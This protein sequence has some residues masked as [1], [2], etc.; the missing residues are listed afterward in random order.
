MPVANYIPNVSAASTTSSYIHETFNQ[1][2]ANGCIGDPLGELAY[3]YIRVSSAQQAEDGRSGLP[4][5][6]Q[7]CDEAARQQHLRIQ[8]EFVFVDDGFSGFEFENRPA[9]NRLREE[10]K[11]SPRTRYIVIEHLDRLSRNARWHQGFLLEEFSKYHVTPIFWKAFGSEIERAVLGTIAE[12]GMRSEI[13][14]MNEGLRHKAVSGRVTAKRPRFGYLFVDSEGQPSEKARK[15]THY[16]LHPENAKIVR[17]IFECIIKERKSL[18]MIA[19]EMNKE[20]IPTTF[21]GKIWCSATIWHIVSD[22]TYKGDFY[23]HRYYMVKTGRFNAQ[24]RATQMTKQRPPAEWIKVNVPPIVTPSEWQ[25]VQDIL[26][27][28]QSRSTR[29]MKKRE[30]L[31]SSFCK[32]DLCKYAYVSIMGGSKKSP[33][34][35]Y[36]CH[37]RNTDRALVTDVACHSPYVT[38][39][40]LEKFVWGK[41]EELVTNPELF[42]RLAQEAENDTQVVEEEIQLQYIG[43]QIADITGRY[44]QWKRAYETKVITLQEYESHRTEYN[45]R[46]LELE[47]AKHD[48][49]KKIGKRLS[50]AER[51]KL[52]LAGLAELNRGLPQTEPN[53]DIP[54]D[55]KRRL[56]QQLLDCIWID[57]Q[58]KTIRFEGVLK[59]NYTEE[60]TWF[61]FGSNR[62]WQ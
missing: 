39:E 57:S 28:N 7:H 55:L 6:L 19:C 43:D 23:A 5:Q 54:F 16:A 46:K 3:A 4:R 8:W 60:E 24:G 21:N 1:L 53:V 51:R 17:W 40:L 13:S 26:K 27:A 14:R 58:A 15:D 11:K 49:E 29:N 32:C 45:R 18:R 34:R 25:L 33:I 37:G 12:E 22:T 48:I 36:G 56:M 50:R 2:A 61:V 42:L 10:I 20:G 62:K 59:T 38:A 30:W 52:I 35:Y 47:E 31:L 44:E 41:V 9:L